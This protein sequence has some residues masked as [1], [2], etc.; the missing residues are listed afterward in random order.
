MRGTCDEGDLRAPSRR[1]I[2]GL[3]FCALHISGWA[4][5]ALCVL[6]LVV[7]LVAGLWPFHSPRSKV[8]WVANENALRF[9]D[10]GTVL[11]SE[12]FVFAGSDGPSCSLE[13]WVEPA[14][15]WSTGSILAFYGSSNLLPFS[16][17]QDLTDLVLQLGPGSEDRLTA[18]AQVR[19]GDVFL[20][21]QA[22]ITVTSD[23]RSTA[24]YLDGQ[25]ITRSPGFGLSL[26]NLA[27]QLILANSPFRSHNWQ[28]QVRGLAIYETELSRE[29]V[30]QHYLGWTQR[31]EPT[32]GKADRA[33]ALYL[34]NE[35]TGR[36]VHNTI[37]SGVELDIPMRYL[38]VHQLLF[39]SPAAEFRSEPNYLNNALFNIAGFIPLGF[40]FSLYFTVAWRMKHAALLSV[41]L[42]GAVSIL[43]ELS[44]AYLPTRYSGMTDIITNTVGTLIGVVLCRI[45]ASPLAPILMSKCRAWFSGTNPSR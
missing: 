19:V 32:V 31:G 2:T 21:K 3:P 30:V 5:G 12:A 7:T 27:G 24:V 38:V 36:T 18:P 28:G 39:E 10:A 29:Q 33:V 26:N 37:G 22:F 40:C 1:Q 17:Q 45:I 9:G 42:G 4:P 14:R 25:L 35:R 11:S 8:S 13:I 20:K 44:Q 23:G 43:I 15:A 34:F 41:V 6:T 16:M